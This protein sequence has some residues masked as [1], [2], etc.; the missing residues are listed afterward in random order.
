[1]SQIY[2]FGTDTN[3]VSFKFIDLFIY[4]FFMYQTVG[5]EL[6]TVISKFTNTD[7]A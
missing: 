3:L 2:G 4:N 1:M 7:L 5:C 6:L